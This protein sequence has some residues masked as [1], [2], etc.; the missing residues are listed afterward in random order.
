MDRRFLLLFGFVLLCLCA[1]LCGLLLPIY[2]TGA[3]NRAERLTPVPAAVLEDSQPGQEVMVEGRVS[4]LNPAQYGPFVAYVREERQV[5][6]DKG[7]PVAG[8]WK[9]VERVTPP[10]LLELP[11]GPVQIENR[12]YNLVGARTVEKPGSGL[13]RYTDSR[14]SGIEAGDHVMAIGSVVAAAERPQIYA[15]FVYRGSRAQYIGGQRSAVLFGIVGG[16]VLAVAGGALV[17]W[18][19]AGGLVP[20]WPWPIR[21]P[22]G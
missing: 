18:G 4:S 5:N 1:P 8:S 6:V 11:D 14:Y 3:A 2:S 17:A 21:W 12:S 22:L 9:E 13:Y 20:R 7:T 19:L 15:E 16:I 10:L